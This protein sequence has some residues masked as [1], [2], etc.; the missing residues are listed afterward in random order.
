MFNAVAPRMREVSTTALKTLAAALTVSLAA[1]AL[2]AQAANLNIAN[3]DEPGTLDPQKSSGNW[4]TRIT[5]ELFATLVAIDSK[6]EL[7]PGLASR[8]EISDDGLTYTFYLRDAKW[9]D[10]K[11]I[12]ADDAVFALRREISPATAAYNANLYFTI[13]NA[14]EIVAGKA[15][16]E[17]LG[18]EAVDQHTLKIHLTQP[19]PSM[20]QAL[21]M[22]ESAPLPRHYI[23]AQQ[24]N[25]VKAGKLVVSGP[26]QLTRWIPQSDIELSK[27]PQFY[28]AD[29]VKLDTAHFY[30]INDAQAALNRFRTGE[31]G[32]S[33]TGV[34]A[35]QFP[36]VKKNFPNEL[37][38]APLLGEYYYVLNLSKGQP[39]ADKRVREA[40]N[41]AV[42][43]GIIANRIL[44]QGQTPSYWYLPKAMEGNA[45]GEM[46]FAHQPMAERLKKAKQLLADAGYGPEHPLH[47]EIAYNTLEDH[48][49]IAVAISAMWKQIGVT[50]TLT[51][52]EAAVHFNT[53]KNG[54]FEVGRYG[55]VATVNDPQDFLKNFVT[56]YEG[57]Y[58]R[59]H[60]ARYDKLVD[61]I[62]RELDPQKRARLLT[63]AQQL[64]LDDY[65]LLP[66]YDYVSINLVSD[67]VKGWH[68]NPLDVH[69]LRYLSVAQ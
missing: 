51:N 20:L 48:R 17:T 36:T 69:P 23:E 58:S 68:T 9:S 32:I 55:G 22:P 63:E 49:R 61:A 57:N 24:G 42:R 12:T 6:A 8:W 45:G 5:R 38:V 30:P 59:Y 14:K 67:K 50:T 10:G 34:P 41:L 21:S 53:L 47:L 44:G 28:A 56:G 1:A 13:K 64:L 4:E 40:L 66:I 16:P 60:N 29:S 15:K 52:S 3:G 31:L 33:Y 54:N 39:T 62:G 11:P 25:W 2:P 37:K 26:F 65:A 27:N 43:R 18:V 46:P 35:T 19:T 7:V